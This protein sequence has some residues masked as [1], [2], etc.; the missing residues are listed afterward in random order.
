VEAKIVQ[1]FSSGLVPAKGKKIIV[2]GLNSPYLIAM[3]L[4]LGFHVSVYEEDSHVFELFSPIL[5]E[6][7]EHAS[8]LVIYQTSFFKEYTSVSPHDGL[9]F[10]A[11]LPEFNERYFDCVKEKN[12]IVF[13]VV[14]QVPCMEACLW[15]ITEEGR[16]TK[17]VLFETSIPYLL[18]APQ[19]KGFFF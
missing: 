19:K 2:V 5:K 11:A 13:A 8:S 14:G 7:S 10:C 9:I 6:R 12:S 1:A 17:E 16:R 3:L 4:E 18:G 15:K